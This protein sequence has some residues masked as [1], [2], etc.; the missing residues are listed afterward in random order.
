[1][2][3]SRPTVHEPATALTR[4]RALRLVCFA[5]VVFSALP[6]AAGKKTYSASKDPFQRTLQRFVDV[7]YPHRGIPKIASD[8]GSWRGVDGGRRTIPHRGIDIKM[9]YGT[10]V[11]AA[12]RGSARS[13][14]S[15]E[16]GL[17]VEINHPAKYYLELVDSDIKI[18]YTFGTTY[19]HLS[20]SFVPKGSKW[21]ERGDIIGEVGSSGSGA[22]DVTHLHFS[23]FNHN[24]PKYWNVN[25]HLLWAKGPGIVSCFDPTE[26]Y[27]RHTPLVITYPVRCDE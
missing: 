9:P 5:G 14:W 15:S 7:Q 1:M 12:A 24:A 4:R 16:G 27:P 26:N 2:C 6:L 11:I 20:K 13:Y 22:F 10:E 3:A 19:S 21:V 25:P 18:P 8:Y 23:V 17:L